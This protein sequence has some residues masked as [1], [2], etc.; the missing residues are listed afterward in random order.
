MDLN[1]VRSEEINTPVFKKASPFSKVIRSIVSR[2]VISL[3]DKDNRM[4]YR[5]QIPEASRNVEISV[6]GLVRLLIREPIKLAYLLRVVKHWHSHYFGAQKKTLD[7]MRYFV[8]TEKDHQIP[9]VPEEDIMYAYMFP[10]IFFVIGEISKFISNREMKEYAKGF[11]ELNVLANK[12]FLQRPTLMPRF[13]EHQRLSLKVVQNIDHPL[14]CC[15]SLHIAYSIM[16]DN[17]SEKMVR[18]YPE[19]ADKFSTIRYSTKRM[20]NSVLYVKQHSLLD[21]AFGILCSKIIYEKHFC[22]NILRGRNFFITIT[23][24]V[25]F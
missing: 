4:A 21:I 5:N 17:I 11:T 22:S 25:N 1:Q 7:Q 23:F 12:T 18:K 13:L 14:N 15:P 9:F 10:Q 6:E 16:L 19:F 24:Q 8:Y 2:V 20:C 3:S